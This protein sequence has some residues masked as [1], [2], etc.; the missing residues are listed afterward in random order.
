MA[1]GPLQIKAISGHAGTV[2][3]KNTS[4]DYDVCKLIDVTTCIGCKAC[5]V[6]CLEWNG[7]PFRETVFDNTYQTM[8]DTEWN[9][10]NLIR[11]NEFTDE[12]GNFS[13]LMRKDQCMHCADPGCLRACPADGAIVQYTNGIV[14]FQQEHCIGCQYCVTGCPFNI[15]KFNKET[16]KVHKCT[17]CSDRVGA[18]LEPA[19]IKACPTGCLH[20]GTKDD[21]KDLAETRAVQLREHTSHKDA[22][23]YDPAGVS[24]TH[25]IYVLHDIN[26]PERYG[27][28]PKDPRVPWMVR[29][30][31]GPLKWVGSLAMAAGIAGVAAHYMRFGPKEVEPEPNPKAPPQKGSDQ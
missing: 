8:P 17:L 21:M 20:F 10:Y 28:L 29:I 5:E 23:V 2:P 11:F 27:G 30:W 24:G 31:K 6:A 13:W 22:G 14:D 4:R 7:Y 18:G 3:G 26:H 1:N 16:K 12:N 15:P 9:Y 19:C 25:V